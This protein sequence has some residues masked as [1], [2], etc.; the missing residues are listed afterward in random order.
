MTDLSAEVSRTDNSS[1]VQ[2]ITRARVLARLEAQFGLN[3]KVLDHAI[4][5]SITSISKFFAYQVPIADGVVSEVLSEGRFMCF[6]Q[7]KIFGFQFPE[8]VLTTN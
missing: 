2:S 6:T 3:S 7:T 1:N 4:P 8:S 5:I